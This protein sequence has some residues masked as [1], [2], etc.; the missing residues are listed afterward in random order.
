MFIYQLNLYYEETITII[1]NKVYDEKEI[2]TNIPWSVMKNVLYL[3]AKHVHF[4]CND[5]IYIQIDVVA[6]GS[7]LGPLLAGIVMVLE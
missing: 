7:P 2:E 5:E 4:A 3:S 1:L 6:L